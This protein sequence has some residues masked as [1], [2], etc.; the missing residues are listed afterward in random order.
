[1]KPIVIIAISI[2]CSVVAV[3][4][5]LAGFVGVSNIE[6]EKQN[7]N[8]QKYYADLDLAESYRVEYDKIA[9]NLCMKSPPPSTYDEAE[10]QLSKSKQLLEYSIQVQPRVFT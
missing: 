3:L 2:V 9:W 4:G 1:M 8:L 7:K 10:I 6:A 5:I